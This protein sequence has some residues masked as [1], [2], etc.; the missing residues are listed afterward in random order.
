M[1]VSI[2]RIDRREDEQVVI[3]CAEIT[4]E[5]EEIRAF[6][7]GR[8]S[9]LSGYTENEDGEWQLERCRLADVCYF[10]AVDELVFA[11]TAD[12]VYRIKQRLYEVE[13]MYAGQNFI[14]CSKSV[15]LNLMK[16]GGIAPELNGRFIAKMK[17]G[18]RL[19]VSRQYAPELRR[20]VMEGGKR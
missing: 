18:E 3:E 15:V 12:R 6:A 14:R 5:V 19:I 7:E 11:Y 4:P 2:R 20:T 1:K 10:E 17:N 9:E 8:E 16:L 13:R